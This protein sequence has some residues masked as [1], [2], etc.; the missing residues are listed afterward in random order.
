MKKIINSIIL[1]FF[2]IDNISAQL[3]NNESMEK[4]GTAAAQFLKIPFDS[5]GSAMGNTGVS[6]PGTIGSSYWNPATIAAVEQNEFGILSAKWLADINIDFF[7]FILATKKFGNPINS[8]CPIKPGR[9]VDPSIL[10][11]NDDG[12]TVAFCCKSCLNQFKQ[13]QMET[14]GIAKNSSSAPSHDYGNYV[15]DRNS[16]RASEVGSPAP[17]G[18]LIREFG[19]S[20][21]DQIEGSHKQASVTQVLNLLNGYVEKNLLKNDKVRILDIVKQGKTVDSKIN[22]AFLAVLNREPSSSEIRNF[23]DAIRSSEHPEK[24]LIWVLV[25]SHEFLFVQ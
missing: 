2:V 5:K 12:D 1:T 19:A 16:V 11:F 13:K 17:N 8:D 21:R 14:P 3:D 15:K 6:M 24:D 7:G 25:N 23:K 22:K 20:S 18:H 9:P 4:A 10:A